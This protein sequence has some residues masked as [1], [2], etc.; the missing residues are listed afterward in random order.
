MS[1]KPIDP[2]QAPVT[3][4]KTIKEWLE[5]PTF[6]LQVANSLPKHLTADRYL[7]VARNT[8]NGSPKLKECTVESILDCIIK[9]SQLGIEIDGR[10]CHLIPFGDKCT[11]VIDYKGIAELVR[12]SGDV[13]AIHM[14]VVCEND[15][16]EFQHGTGKHL[17]HRPAL[18]NRGKIVAAYSFVNLNGTSEEFDVM[19]MDDIMEVRDGSRGYQNAIEKKKD[20]PWISSFA[21]MAKKTAFRRHSKILPLSPEIRTA[22]ELDDDAIEVEST[23]TSSHSNAPKFLGRPKESVVS[24][25]ADPIP[26]VQ[27][28]PEPEKETKEP[29]QQ[30][31]DPAPAKP[32]EPVTPTPA[33]ATPAAVPDP[34]KGPKRAMLE[35]FM[36]EDGITEQQLVQYMQNSSPVLLKPGQN[37]ADMAEAKCNL[38]CSMWK[39][40]TEAI[41][42][43]K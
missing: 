29:V 13:Q 27:P 6:K 41:K 21:E 31:A 3:R 42:G 30:P 17:I 18:K 25:T 19:D 28:D 32:A 38:V 43:G 40:I 15:F 36:Q 20:H 22:V 23:V 8:I 12:R 34:K 33:P 9:V 37:F 4:N 39:L 11:L 1:V 35:S 7:A 14:D 5:E 2:N 24:Q 26:L 16:F 10:R